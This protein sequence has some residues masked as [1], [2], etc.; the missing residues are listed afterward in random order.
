MA[1]KFSSL[2]LTL[3][4]IATALLL[5]S[6]A[7]PA[8]S[9]RAS[10][11]RVATEGGALI[12]SVEGEGARIDA[13]AIDSEY[14][15]V[16]GT[17][18]SYQA[19]RIEKRRLS[20]GSLVSSFGNNGV[21]I[22]KSGPYVVNATASD[23]AI[24]GEFMY[25]VGWVN[26]P[27]YIVAKYGYIQKRRLDDGSLVWERESDAY[28]VFY[29]GI[30]IDSDYM[31][32]VGERYGGSSDDH[33]RIEKRNLS[34]G[35]LVSSFGE[36]GVVKI[37]K[38]SGADTKNTF[39]DVA[40]DDSYIYAAGFY[41]TGLLQKAFVAKVDKTT[42]QRD[43][44]FGFEG[45][46]DLASPYA[47]AYAVV[48]DQNFLYVASGRDVTD[49]P[50]W[51]IYKLN[52]SSGAT[53]VSKSFDG[54]GREGARAI[55]LDGGFLYIGGYDSNT[56]GGDNQ[57]RMEARRACDGALYPYF[58]QGGVV[59]EDIRPG[60]VESVLAMAVDEEHLYV[61]GSHWRI[62]KRTKVAPPSPPPQTS[63][64]WLGTLGGEESYA[65]DVSDNGIVVG[66]AEDALG[67][68]RP[69]R[70]S[71][72]GGMQDLGTLGGEWGYATGISADGTSITGAAGNAEGLSRAFRWSPAGMQDLGTL[73]GTRSWAWGISADGSVIIGDAFTPEEV[74]HAFRWVEGS[75]MQDLGTLGG[76]W[77]S[78]EGVSENG[79]V[80]VGTS[81]T[82]NSPHAFRWTSET[83]MQDLGTLGG[84]D[85]AAYGVS[86]DGSVVVGGA[87]TSEG[88]EQ[89]FQW[90]LGE[91]MQAL[92][93]EESVA[94]DVS[95]DGTIV[96]GKLVDVWPQTWAFRWTSIGG[97]EDLNIAYA[98]L[99]SDGSVLKEARAISPDG[100]FIAGCGCNAA[101]G[102]DEA[103]L[104]DTRLATPTWIYL[105]LVL[106]GTR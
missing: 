20:D 86:A 35:S 13:I 56:A 89:A 95:A 9:Q 104:L 10:A 78:A 14:M 39:L 8:I 50:G 31:Y 49:R 27:S 43:T 94:Y 46:R 76:D 87:R 90:L 36:N 92:V 70:W 28:Y 74:P 63:L 15:Y 23:I 67:R 21:I 68:Y 64:T 45:T 60:E 98:G 53:E 77:S 80:V 51:L 16:V 22:D 24:D 93:D 65:Y 72:A 103:Y 52:K 7:A 97:W 11:W 25:V 44:N 26:Y 91:G 88:R 85:S 100:R 99:L 37:T 75:G 4:S 102:Q 81:R 58:G 66:R 55:A 29:Y 82:S 42:G 38:V 62:E 105:P 40:I 61:A 71:A 73:G 59:V 30:A 32:I 83:G 6:L 41:G 3:I 33:A 1:K 18:S 48:V 101:T 69:F 84:V 106:K 79:L 34:D 47:A 54:S 5:C 17:D 12:W 57:W 2:R 96:V 19:W